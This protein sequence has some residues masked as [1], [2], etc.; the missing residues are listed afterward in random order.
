MVMDMSI[1]SAL[2]FGDASQVHHLAVLKT[3]LLRRQRAPMVKDM[4]K[5][6]LA[7]L[8]LAVD[9]HVNKAGLAGSG[10]NTSRPMERA[11]AKE[12]ARSKGTPDQVRC[13]P[14]N[15]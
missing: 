1:L 5:T 13:C 4:A 7:D 2:L 12:K 3:H 8:P 6:R 14:G 10:G 11:M 9:T 15:T